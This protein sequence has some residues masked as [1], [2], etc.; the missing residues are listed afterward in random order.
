M[1]SPCRIELHGRNLGLDNGWLSPPGSAGAVFRSD[2]SLE[3]FSEV[4]G[5]VLVGDMLCVVDSDSVRTRNGA[6]ETRVDCVGTVQGS[7]ARVARLGADRED[8]R[9]FK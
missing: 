7:P 4:G 6:C 9:D 2:S 3:E 8:P 5:E 1:V